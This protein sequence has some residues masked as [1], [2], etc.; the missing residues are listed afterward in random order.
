MI[1]APY[2]FLSFDVHWMQEALGNILDNAIKYSYNGGKVQISVTN[3]GLF[4]CIHVKDSGCGIREEEQGLIFQRFYRAESSYN[5]QGLGIGLYLAREIVWQHA[6]YI[7]VQS[8]KGEGAE[9]RV[10]LPQD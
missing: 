3:Y 5:K 9:F 10:Y 4:W 7:E 2:E 6:G 1:P 8:K